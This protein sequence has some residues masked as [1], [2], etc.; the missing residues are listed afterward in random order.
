[1][2]V[3]QIYPHTTPHLQNIQTPNPVLV[4]YDFPQ[5]VP[6]IPCQN[7]QTFTRYMLH[8]LQKYMS[9]HLSLLHAE[10]IFPLLACNPVARAV[11]KT[12][13]PGTYLPGERGKENK[14]S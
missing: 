2:K 11:Q 6:L 4:I 13:N 1:M 7:K 10:G 14:V 12:R 8:K 3:K 5:G 9:S